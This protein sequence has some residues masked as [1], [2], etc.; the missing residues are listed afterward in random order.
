MWLQWICSYVF[1]PIAWLMGA[2]ADA[3]KVARLIAVKTFLNEFVAYHGI[4]ILMIQK[5]CC[6][7]LKY[8]LRYVDYYQYKNLVIM[9]NKRLQSSGKNV[10]LGRHD[11]RVLF[12]FLFPKCFLYLYGA[13]SSNAKSVCNGKVEGLKSVKTIF[14]M[15]LFL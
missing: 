9:L 15:P 4:Y 5:Y 1:Y 2:S 11:D 13:S 6:F 8:V 7:S 10:Q 3:R 14:D 12:R